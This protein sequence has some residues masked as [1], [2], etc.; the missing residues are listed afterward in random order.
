MVVPAIAFVSPNRIPWTS[1]GKAWQFNIRHHDNWQFAFGVTRKERP[2]TPHERDHNGTSGDC[3]ELR[4]S[5]GNTK[6]A[7]SGGSP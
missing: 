4:H 1:G 5:G 7:H 3:C 6:T 2:E